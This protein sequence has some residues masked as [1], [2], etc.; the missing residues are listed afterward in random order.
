MIMCFRL[1]WKMVHEPILYCETLDNGCCFLWH[2][3]L[4]FC[5]KKNKEEDEEERKT[6]VLFISLVCCM[7]L[8]LDGAIK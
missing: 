2:E 6:I 5:K 1:C 4:F 7:D 3:S 8:F